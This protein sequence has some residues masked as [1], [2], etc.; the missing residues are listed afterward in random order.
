MRNSNLS[1]LPEIK[2][3]DGISLVTHKDGMEKAWEGLIEASFESH[4]DFDDTLRNWRGYAPENV[5]YILKGDKVFSTASAV[6]NQYYPSEGWLHMVG[7]HPDARRLGFGKVVTLAALH[8]F[9]KRGYKSVVLSTDDFRIAAIK[10][11]LKLGF[12]PVCSDDTH[13]ECWNKI[14]EIIK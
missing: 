3:P 10:T 2:L 11:Y 7:T 6:E 12:E 4:S 13:E 5:F 9:K 8:S 1:V 14:R